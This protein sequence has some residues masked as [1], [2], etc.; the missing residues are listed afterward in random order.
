MRHGDAVAIGMMCAARLAQN[1]QWCDDAFVTRIEKL[2]R[3]IGL[4]TRIPRELATDSIL[5]AM[6]TDKKTLN[7]KLHFIVPRG[8]GDVVIAND[9]RSEEVEQVLEETRER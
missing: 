4:P 5:A 1:R 2:L 7:G 3:A 8:L 9:V 6:Q